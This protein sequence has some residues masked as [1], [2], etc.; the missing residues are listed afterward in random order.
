MQAKRFPLMV[1]KKTKV[2]WTKH[3][4]ARGFKPR[5]HSDDEVINALLDF[6]EATVTQGS[7]KHDGGFLY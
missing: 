5:I 3:R 4:R 7:K 1:Y 6:Y 2:R